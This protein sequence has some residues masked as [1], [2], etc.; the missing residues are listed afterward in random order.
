V[1]ATVPVTLDA[2][3]MGLLSAAQQLKAA[4]ADGI[5]VWFFRKMQ[6]ISNC[7]VVLIES[8][9]SEVQISHNEF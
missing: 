3:Q 7:V 8:S 5:L 9:Y 1:V 4:G 2:I 6:L